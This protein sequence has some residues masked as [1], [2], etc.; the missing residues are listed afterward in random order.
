MYV[1]VDPFGVDRQI[2]KI[3]GLC[4]GGDQ[5]LVCLKNRFPQIVRPEKAS[6]Y[7]QILFRI[8][9]LRVVRLSDE[10]FDADERC[11]DRYL[12]QVLGDLFPADSRNDPLAQIRCRKIGNQY[13]VVVE[14]KR[15]IR[16]T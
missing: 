2:E 12:Q 8:V 11:V 3:G 9:F 1:D 4:L 14:R 5:F 6:V 15:N 7:E 13:V 10:S 16:I